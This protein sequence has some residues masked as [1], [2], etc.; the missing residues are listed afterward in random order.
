MTV[1]RTAG[2]VWYLCKYVSAPDLDRVGGRGYSIMSEL[3]ERGHEVVLITSDSNHLANPPTFEGA[4]CRRRTGRLTMIWL[5]TLK[6]DGTGSF[7]RVL[8][9]FDFEWR[10]FRF[11]ARGLPRP[12]AVI[13]SSLSLLTV[14]NGVRLKR[15]YHARLILEIRDIWPLTLTEQGGVSRWHPLALMLRLVERLGY[16]SADVVVGTMPNLKAHVAKSTSRPVPVLT[17]PQGFDPTSLTGST[18][19]EPL[20]SLGTLEGRDFVVGYVGTVGFDNALDSFFLAAAEMETD[21][22]TAFVLVGEGSLL[23]GY[24]AQYGHLKNLFII[25]GVPKREVQ[26]V[27]SQFDILYFA[28]HPSAVWNYGQSLNKVIDYMLAGKPVIGSYSGFPS[29][30]DEAECGVFVPAGDVEALVAEV[31]RFAAMSKAERAAM[32]K[33]GADWVRERRT[34]TQLAADYEEILFP[35]GAPNG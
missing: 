22:G 28:T 1:E 30:I 11:N 24:R 18:D 33:R 15:K 3:A 27:L 20:K 21:P 35:A 12:D 7:R 8:S 6:Y 5:R 32:G 13:A 34:F 29:M 14:L 2:A 9:W 4:S 25:G 31:R 10:L 16:R 26:A 17:I 23:D 19:P